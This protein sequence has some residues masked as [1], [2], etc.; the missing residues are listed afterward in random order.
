MFTHHPA[1][2][3]EPHLQNALGYHVFHVVAMNLLSSLQDS[4]ANSISFLK[5]LTL[6]LRGVS[7]DFK[8]LADQ[9]SELPVFDVIENLPHTR[10]SPSAFFQGPGLALKKLMV[11]LPSSY[12]AVLFEMLSLMPKADFQKLFTARIFPCVSG[13]LQIERSHYELSGHSA[14]RFKLGHSE[15]HLGLSFDFLQKPNSPHISLLGAFNPFSPSQFKGVV[16]LKE[17]E[18]SRAFSVNSGLPGV[19]S[20]NFGYEQLLHSVQ[21]NVSMATLGGAFTKVWEEVSLNLGGFQ[22]NT[23]GVLSVYFNSKL[24]GKFEGVHFN[25]QGALIDNTVGC[26]TRYLHDGTEF[27]WHGPFDSL[28]SMR[29]NSIGQVTLKLVNGH[30]VQLCNAQMGHGNRLAPGLLNP[31]T[32]C[33]PQKNKQIIL[34]VL[35]QPDGLL[36]LTRRVTVQTLSASGLLLET[37]AGSLRDLDLFSDRLFFE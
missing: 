30:V 6:Q 13:H 20:I 17:S 19:T 25:E 14:I 23:R 37:Q 9:Q 21:G 34:G 24:I 15:Q 16:L 18:M 29:A 12:H 31:I 32:L 8:K 27:I 36:D 35:L 3:A 10:L 28:G 7:L 33:Y 4:K 11:A 26:L 2:N 1:Q 5:E 22:Y